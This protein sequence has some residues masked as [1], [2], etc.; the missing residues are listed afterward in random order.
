VS[1]TIFKV[2]GSLLVL[3]FLES[4]Y[5]AD[6]VTRLYKTC[7]AKSAKLRPGQKCFQDDFPSGQ[8]VPDPDSGAGG[9]GK[10]FA[11]GSGAPGQGDWDSVINGWARRRESGHRPAAK[12]RSGQ[13]RG[14]YLESMR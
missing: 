14:G 7:H 11:E 12:G 2:L 10:V 13:V 9:I 5:D 6:I 1:A 4:C 3:L 8:N